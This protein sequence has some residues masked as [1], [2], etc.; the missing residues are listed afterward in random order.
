[1]RRH[2]LMWLLICAWVLWEQL[3]GIAGQ[4][5]EVRWN[6]LEAF[7]TR[8]TCQEQARTEEKRITEE[9]GKAKKFPPGS[10]VVPRRVICLPDTVDPRPRS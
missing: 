8:P 7:E 1:M 3:G 2:A 5:A 10:V 6:I 9:K 4:P